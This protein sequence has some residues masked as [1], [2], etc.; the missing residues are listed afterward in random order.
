M[1]EHPHDTGPGTIT[2]RRHP[3]IRRHRRPSSR[4]RRIVV[5]GVAGGVVVI[6]AVLAVSAAKSILDAKHAL[7]D[8][9]AAVD[10]VTASPRHLT[11]ATARAQTEQLINQVNADVSR[12]RHD[13]D[14]SPGVSVMWALP[15]LHSQRQATLNLLNNVQTT[16]TA[17]LG[18]LGTVDQL[19]D[20]SHGTTVALP[21][22]KQ[23][24]RQTAA[25]EARLAPLDHQQKGILPLVGP[26]ANAQQS[27]DRQETHIVNLLGDGKELTSYALNFLG[28]D[29]P[30]TYFLA[31]ENNAEIRDQGTI[32]SYALITADNGTF[33]VSNDASIANVPLPS[34]A[35]VP[36]PGGTAQVFGWLHPT[37]SFQFTNATADF[38]WSGK[39]MAAMY[40]HATGQ[41]VNGVIALDVP[42]LSRLLSVVG[43]VQVPGIAE[44]V[45]ANNLSEIVLHQVYQGITPSSPSQIQKNDVLSAVAKAVVDKMKGGHVDLASFADALA[46]A[47]A[48]RHLLAWDQNP[49]NE[50][51]ITKF[52]AS[53][54]IDTI[55]PTHTFHVAVENV[56]ANK[57]DYYVKVAVHSQVTITPSGDARVVTSVTTINPAPANQPP[58]DQLGPFTGSG[59]VEGE[60][61][62]YV[63]L[64]GPRG[65]EQYGSVAESGLR[66]SQA[67]E[68]VM[69]QT[70]HTIRFE[71]TIPHAVVNG[72]LRLVFV[73]QPRLVPQQLTVQVTG[74]GWHVGG[75][76]TVSAP[77]SRTLSYTWAVSR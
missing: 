39:A 64:W 52:G 34:A 53:G 71:S 27:F 12:A 62:A 47:T 19:V 56:S 22:L 57:L 40:L 6:V 11:S 7:D 51:T 75:N 77:M 13:L 65:A 36:T 70:T 31:A 1:F 17:G 38:P 29:G 41:P 46:N 63:Y 49:R 3:E 18:L 43:P 24:Q 8:A 55:D 58:S 73:P 68:D 23:L 33:Q 45:T 67:T 32:L 25:A 30:R 66:V 26:L 4:R 72:R 20:A 60:Y 74:D 37:L 5:L 59:Y 14:T 42:G 44:P 76:S 69:A 50:N 15:W 2:K 48:G 21:Q 28:A 10:Q 61:G 9:R 16:A 35:S 54:A